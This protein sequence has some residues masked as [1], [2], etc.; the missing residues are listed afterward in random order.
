MQTYVHT[1]G[2][3]S[4]AEDTADVPWNDMWYAHAQLFFTCHLRPSGGSQPKNPSYKI[5]P[6]DS[7]FNLFLFSTFEE[8][9]L[10]IRGPMEGAGV[11]KLHEPAYTLPLRGSN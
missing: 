3:L 6:D 5:G 2:T 7:L 10:P 8:L 4:I 1:L 11:L 9:H